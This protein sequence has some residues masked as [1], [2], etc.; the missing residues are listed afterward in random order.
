MI[1]YKNDTAD[2]VLVETLELKMEGLVIEDQENQ[3][4]VLVRI[5]P[6]EKKVI[7]LTTT[8]GGYSFGSSCSFMVEDA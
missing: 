3:T 7:K 8:G 4:A 6:G 1:I 5:G 2:K